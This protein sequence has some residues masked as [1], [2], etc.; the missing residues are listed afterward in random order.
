MAQ[1]KAE[2]HHDVAVWIMALGIAFALALFLTA[3]FNI[4]PWEDHTYQM[5]PPIVAGMP[6]PHRDGREEMVCSSCHIV[7]QPKLASNAPP[8]AVLPI[9]AGTPS[10]H[11]DNRA[12]MTCANCH[13]IVPKGGGAVAAP[14]SS[15]PQP[16]SLPVALPQSLPD[17]AQFGPA[18]GAGEEELTIPPY[19]FQGRVLKVAGSGAG[20]QWSD[21]YI[22]LDDR[23]NDPVWINLAPRWYLQAGGCHVRAGMFVKGLAFRDQTPDNPS[24]AYAMSLMVNGE[25]CRLRDR[26]MSGLWLRNEGA[27]DA[28]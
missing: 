28:E 26:H 14:Q 24:P 5:A 23:I 1:A 19:R 4:N 10:P 6:A 11:T 22:L 18:M 7:T 12:K 20:S 8:G 25:F 3:V 13:T 9:V 17:T 15:A 27:A 21:V 2:S 16:R